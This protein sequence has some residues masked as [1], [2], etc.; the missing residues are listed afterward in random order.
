MVE[1]TFRV[2]ETDSGSFRWRLRHA[3]G[4]VVA[5]SDGT[6]PTRQAAMA[7]VQ[8]VKHVAAEA[9]VDSLGPDDPA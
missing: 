5:S 8:R 2:F 6:Y 7:D 1:A 3:D 4:T 9:G